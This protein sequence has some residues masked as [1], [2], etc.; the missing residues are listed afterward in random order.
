MTREW[1]SLKIGCRDV[2]VM[3]LRLALDRESVTCIDR[4][5]KPMHNNIGAARETREHGAL[6][7][8]RQR[9]PEL[10]VDNML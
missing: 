6:H 5:S 7:V 8:A 10:R 9:L 3:V 4:W 2:L 1:Q